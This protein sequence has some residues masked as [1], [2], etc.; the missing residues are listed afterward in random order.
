MVLIKMIELAGGG[1]G[2]VWFQ[3]TLANILTNF[4]QDIT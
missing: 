4:D 2:S 3:C 1:G